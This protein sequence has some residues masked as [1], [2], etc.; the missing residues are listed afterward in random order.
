MFR[1]YGE[2]LNHVCGKTHFDL[3]CSSLNWAIYELPSF[4]NL[5][6]KAMHQYTVDS[7]D[8]EC[9]MLP[10]QKPLISHLI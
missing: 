5:G 9:G 2:L 4:T 3:F 6:N 8:D 7:D 10:D 1:K